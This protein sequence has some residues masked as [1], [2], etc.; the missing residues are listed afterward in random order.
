[1]KSLSQ[2]IPFWDYVR[3]L[4]L[5]WFFIFDANFTVYETSKLPWNAWTDA[6][7]FLAIS[8]FYILL[9]PKGFRGCPN[10]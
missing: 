10:L 6:A 7:I 8:G 3:G 5:L 2:Y 1:M 9:S 4:A